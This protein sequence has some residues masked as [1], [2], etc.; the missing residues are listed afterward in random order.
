MVIKVTTM[1]MKV[2]LLL[3]EVDSSSL[4]IAFVVEICIM[5][6]FLFNRMFVLYSLLARFLTSEELFYK[7]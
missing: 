6:N 7:C 3:I 1:M 5:S 2:L 4:Q